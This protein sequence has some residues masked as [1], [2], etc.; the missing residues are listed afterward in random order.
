MTRIPGHIVESTDISK[1]NEYI[2]CKILL[3]E[4]KWELHLKRGKKKASNASYVLKN[5]KKYYL[6]INIINNKISY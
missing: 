5:K 3:A 6:C 2:I 1:Q 4:K